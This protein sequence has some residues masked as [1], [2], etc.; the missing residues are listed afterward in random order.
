MTNTAI[1]YE[2]LQKTYTET[3]KNNAELYSTYG[4]AN[5]TNGAFMIVFVAFMFLMFKIFL[6]QRKL[7]KEIVDLFNK[8]LDVLDDGVKVITNTLTTESNAIKTH[9]TLAPLMAEPI[10]KLPKRVLELHCKVIYNEFR[11]NFYNYIVKNNLKKN[12]KTIEK[13]ICNLESL[14]LSKL[15]KDNVIDMVHKNELEQ[16]IEACLQEVIINYKNVLKQAI[17]SGSVDAYDT[18]R[19]DVESICNELYTKLRKTIDK[20]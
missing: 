11:Y 8:K 14:L 3:L 12:F 1:N 17:E 18:A 19:R 7:N 4:W 10:K 20:Y 6:E 16:E 15:K 9:I 13:E 5:V 2:M